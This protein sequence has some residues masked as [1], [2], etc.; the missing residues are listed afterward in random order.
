MGSSD[1]CSSS[2]SVC[3][4]P[5]LITS[6]APSKALA[7]PNSTLIL[8]VKVM[9]CVGHEGS[10]LL[11]YV[12]NSLLVLYQPIFCVWSDAHQWS[13]I[14]TY[15]SNC[16]R[17]VE[18]CA[19]MKPL[20]SRSRMQPAAAACLVLYWHCVFADWYTST[21]AMSPCYQCFASREPS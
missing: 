17:T 12:D 18:L 11:I 9:W 14:S 5:S 15:W 6:M 3:R 16:V 10:H 1:Q 8:A 4:G 20:L 19:C 13:R 21:W 7:E 2:Y